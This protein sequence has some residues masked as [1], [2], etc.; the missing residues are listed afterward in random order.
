VLGGH[1]RR[2][3]V[4]W[5]PELLSVIGWLDLFRSHGHIGR[6][7]RGESAAKLAPPLP[8]G[9]G[10]AFERVAAYTAITLSFLA[11]TIVA[12]LKN[13]CSPFVCR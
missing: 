4:C 8:I 11:G 1:N 2:F 9:Q 7:Q 5:H 12:F 3:T 13:R 6:N 10:R